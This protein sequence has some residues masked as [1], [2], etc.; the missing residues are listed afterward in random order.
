MAQYDTR[1]LLT[2]VFSGLFSRWGILESHSFH[3][4]VVMTLYNSAHSFL[5]G[6][7]KKETQDGPA[8]AM[9][10]MILFYWPEFGTQPCGISR[11]SAECM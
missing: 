8:L 4:V 7:W 9:W 11:V 10:D 2:V 3:L 6:Q 5:D 1:E